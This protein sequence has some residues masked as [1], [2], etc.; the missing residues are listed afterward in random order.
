MTDNPAVLTALWTLALICT[1]LFTADVHLGMGRHAQYLD[2]AKLVSTVR[3]NLIANP[4][5][6]MAY[7]LP[8][9]SVAI[10]LNHIIAPARYFRLAIY[11][12]AVA[13]TI[14]AA[15]SC[16]LLFAQCTPSEHL[17]NPTVSATCMPPSVIT[18]YS[19]FVGGTGSRHAFCLIRN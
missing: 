11:V 17:W 1:S 9:I 16:I 5:G 14:I 3:L 10:V 6:I 4:F 19:Y 15:I 13:Q 18:G 12:I 8:N 2:Q 7:S